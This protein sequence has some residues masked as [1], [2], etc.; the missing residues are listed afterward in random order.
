MLGHYEFES[1]WYLL[2]PLTV[3]SESLLVAEYDVQL[4]LMPLLEVRDFMS[5]LQDRHLTQQYNPSNTETEKAMCSIL[6]LVVCTGYITFD[7]HYMCS[8]VY[9]IFFN[10]GF[11]NSE[12]LLLSNIF[13]CFQKMLNV[14]TSIH[15]CLAFIIYLIK[16]ITMDGQMATDS[17]V[18]TVFYL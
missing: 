7:S 8:F 2:C 4:A 13:L 17:N 1:L 9:W 15:K 6:G 14:S 5:S 10:L 16:Q 12:K 11:E 3:S 18:S